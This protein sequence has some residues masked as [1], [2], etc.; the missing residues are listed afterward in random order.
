M[1]RS[2]KAPDAVPGEL[3]AHRLVAG[4]D[5]GILLLGPVEI[6]AAMRGVVFVVEIGQALLVALEIAR[7]G[8][9]EL[10]EIGRG[11][12]PVA[13]Q[14]GKAQEVA[15]PQHDALARRLAPGKAAAAVEGI[16]GCHGMGEI[17]ARRRSVTVRHGQ[18]W[19]LARN[20]VPRWGTITF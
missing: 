7:G 19:K 3:V 12:R 2:R 5:R 4:V 14:G 1:A 9:G 11:Q 10:E 8:F 17:E 6:E 15:F 20:N 18:Q 16:D 13:L